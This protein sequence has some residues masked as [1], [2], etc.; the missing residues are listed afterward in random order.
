MPGLVRSARRPPRR[1]ARR[2]RRRPARP[3]PV[4]A[5]RLD[6]LVEHQVRAVHDAP[7][8]AARRAAHVGRRR[9]SRRAARPDARAAMGI[10]A[11]ARAVAT[12]LG[13]RGPGP[14]AGHAP[15]RMASACPSTPSVATMAWPAGSRKLRAKPPATLTMSPRLPDAGD[16]AAQEDLHASAPR[17]S[18]PARPRTVATTSATS[19]TS[20]LDHL[21]DSATSAPRRTGRRRR[22]PAV[23]AASLDSVRSSSRPASPAAAQPP[24]RPPR[25]P[26]PP[27]RSVTV[28]CV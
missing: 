5:D 22:G 23:E 12:R 24:S 20:D 14:R 2:R 7:R 17:P 25:P 3:S 19:A 21:D 10:T 9:P 18:A 16:V 1:S 8:S 4:L 26:R 11:P 13:A 6:V 27:G 15:R 28:R